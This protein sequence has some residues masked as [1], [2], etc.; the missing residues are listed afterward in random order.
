MELGE[1]SLDLAGCARVA[2]D[3]SRNAGQTWGDAAETTSMVGVLSRPHREKSKCVRY[4]RRLANY[5]DFT[6]AQVAAGLDDR[7]EVGDCGF[8]PGFA[9]SLQCIARG[10]EDT[11][12]IHHPQRGDGARK[13]ALCVYLMSQ[14]GKINV[15]GS[16]HFLHLA[17]GGRSYSYDAAGFHIISAVVSVK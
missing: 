6:W 9:R 10:M 1:S 16:A 8:L 15:V 14:V 12:P 2:G 11:I 4:G 13:V 7:P 5:R 3:K 17:V